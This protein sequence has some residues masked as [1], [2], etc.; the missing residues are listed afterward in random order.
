MNIFLVAVTAR[1]HENKVSAEQVVFLV[2][3]S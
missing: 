2:T 1:D 3:S